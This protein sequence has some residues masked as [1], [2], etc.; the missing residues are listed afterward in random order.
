MANVLKFEDL[1]N[2][3][4]PGGSSNNFGVAYQTVFIVDKSLREKHGL[5]NLMKNVFLDR[6]QKE[7]LEL[8]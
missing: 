7:V 3:Q 6:P 8:G 5:Q 2:T 1:L 4:K